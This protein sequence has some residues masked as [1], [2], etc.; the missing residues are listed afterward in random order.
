M[1]VLGQLTARLQQTLREIAPDA[2]V[3]WGPDGGYGHPD[4]RLVSAVVTQIVQEGQGTDRLFYAALPESGLTPGLLASLKFPAPFRATADEYLSVRVPYSTEDA[5]R[6]HDALACHATQ[7][8]PQ[9]MEALSALSE[10]VN[11]GTAYLRPWQG[12]PRGADLF[13]D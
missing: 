6:A 11:R 5:T 13:G 3:T 4:H 2:I 12:G 10:R 7:F 9:T 8:Q 1:R